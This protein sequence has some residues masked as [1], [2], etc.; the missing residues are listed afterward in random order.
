MH[1]PGLRQ[2]LRIAD[3]VGMSK[4]VLNPSPTHKRQ[5]ANA[6]KRVQT[7]LIIG[8]CHRRVY[9]RGRYITYPHL[10]HRDREVTVSWQD[11]GK[12]CRSVRKKCTKAENN[13]RMKKGLGF[14]LALSIILGGKPGIRTL[15]TLLTFAGFQDRCIQ[16]LC[17]FPVTSVMRTA[18]TR[19]NSNLL[20]FFFHAIYG[21]T[22]QP[23]AL[24]AIAGRILPERNTLSNSTCWHFIG[25]CYDRP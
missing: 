14:H 4:S 9:L 2:P 6:N 1:H 23:V 21:L 10:K 22:K 8:V 20:R 7:M 11:A 19:Q 13:Q 15:G 24:T 25:L 18:A 3:L 5:N 17:Q 12:C 16:P